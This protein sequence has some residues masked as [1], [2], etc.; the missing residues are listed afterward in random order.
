MTTILEMLAAKIPPEQEAIWAAG[1]KRWQGG[2]Q[3]GEAGLPCPEDADPMAYK[4][5]VARRRVKAGEIIGYVMR[6][7]K[8]N[9]CG[10]QNYEWRMGCRC[11]TASTWFE[12][13]PGYSM[14][15]GV[16]VEPGSDPSAPESQFMT[17]ERVV[18]LV[19]GGREIL[20]IMTGEPVPIDTTPPSP[21]SDGV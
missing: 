11:W 5:G 19:V 8:C 10:E 20:D 6:S 15:Y 2:Q 9:A 4:S 17:M 12:Q 18:E 14:S 7:C 1:R 3:A 13:V 21:Q 16:Q